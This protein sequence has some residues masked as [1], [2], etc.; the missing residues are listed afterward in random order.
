MVDE[1]EINLRLAGGGGG[2]GG[3]EGTTEAASFQAGRRNGGRERRAEDNP[4]QH[5][6]LVRCSRSTQ[7]H[8]R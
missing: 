4:V 7:A 5:A 1:S 8:S 6:F 2:G 3:A